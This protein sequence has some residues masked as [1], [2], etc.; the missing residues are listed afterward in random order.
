MQ[1]QVTKCREPAAVFFM[2]EYLFCCTSNKRLKSR[3]QQTASPSKPYRYPD[4]RFQQYLLRCITKR[5]DIFQKFCLI[6][7]IGNNCSG[8]TSLWQCQVRCRVRCGAGMRRFQ[9]RCRQAQ[10]GSENRQDAAG[11][12]LSRVFF[13]RSVKWIN[14]K[15]EHDHIQYQKLEQDRGQ[16]FRENLFLL[17]GCVE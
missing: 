13:H 7:D 14:G 15:Q 11:R 17:I 6:G 5:G 1:P 12:F 4:C 10:S 2:P 9:N 8:N 16:F 3:L